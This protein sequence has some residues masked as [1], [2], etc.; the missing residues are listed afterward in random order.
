M[1]AL[2]TVLMLL[3]GA[4]AATPSKV[5]TLHIKT[6]T[7]GRTMTVR[8]YLP[9]DYD[10]QKKYPTAYLLHPYGGNASFWFG[11]M[12]TR[13]V[14]DR[15]LEEKK[16]QPML[17]VSPDYDNSFAVNSREAIAGVNAGRYADY[18]VQE[19][20]PYIDNRYSTTTSRDGR[21]I[22]GTSMGGFAALFLG[23]TYT[24]LFSKIAV[25]SAAI[26]DGNNDLYQDQRDW[27]YATP[28]LKADRDPF[29]LLSKVNLK[30]LVFRVDVGKSDPLRDVNEHLVR[31]LRE[32][33][34]Q[35]E[36]SEEKGGHDTA[37]WSSQLPGLL[38]FFGKAP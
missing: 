3:G 27:L 29:Q 20:I 13:K 38:T 23:L 2:L 26:W 24:E 34:A 16:V 5:E 17:I 36:F 8:V 32:A 14:M 28:A 22:G 4:L 37:Y 10:K 21:F 7:L 30:S 31:A 11:S 19:L 18:I 6:N 1:R 15:L 33:G 12:Q 35:V 9:P 25:Q